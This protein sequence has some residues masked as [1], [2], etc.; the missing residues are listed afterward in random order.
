DEKRNEIVDRLKKQ[1]KKVRKKETL[2]DEKHI[3]KSL[4]A[5][6]VDFTTIVANI[7]SIFSPGNVLGMAL[8]KWFSAI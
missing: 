7:G 6:A 5:A 4:I 2:F 1:F 8:V 3:A